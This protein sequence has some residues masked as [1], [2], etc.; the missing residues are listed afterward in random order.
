MKAHK[1]KSAR[2]SSWLPSEFGKKAMDEIRGAAENAGLQLTQD[3]IE[4]FAE[5]HFLKAL[6]ECASDA[7]GTLNSARLQLLKRSSARTTAKAKNSSDSLIDDELFELL[8]KRGL[9]PKE[10]ILKRAEIKVRGDVELS[11]LHDALHWLQEARQ[12]LENG[13]TLARCVSAAAM[14]EARS[15]D[16]AKAIEQFSCATTFAF[17][18]GLE[19]REFGVRVGLAEPGRKHSQPE[20][21]LYGRAKR[22]YDN[23]RTNGVSDPRPS[24]IITLM[25]HS[26]HHGK[27]S[28]RGKEE[29]NARTVT[30]LVSR[31]L[32]EWKQQDG[33]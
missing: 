23:L 13:C 1:G 16:M 12:A 33:R 2:N 26:P 15:A 18:A 3:Q 5:Q 14:G 24:Q 27:Q 7:A 29:L 17:Y 25:D 22:A 8:L 9:S 28:A 30:N 19:S 21:P 10:A 31:W 32:K 11:R 4:E 6:E 20:H